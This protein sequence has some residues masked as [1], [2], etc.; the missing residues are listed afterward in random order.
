MLLIKMYDISQALVLE[1]VMSVAAEYYFIWWLFCVLTH[2]HQRNNRSEPSPSQKSKVESYGV[3][4]N[5][6]CEVSD[7]LLRS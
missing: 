3:S 7:D 6:L 1:D 2:F 4:L 5:K